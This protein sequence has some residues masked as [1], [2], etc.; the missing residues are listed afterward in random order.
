MTILRRQK[1]I[2]KYEKNEERQRWQ[3]SVHFLPLAG[4]A[5][6]LVAS[7]LAENKEQKL[8]KLPLSFQFSIIHVP[9]LS[10]SRFLAASSLCFL[11][12]ANLAKSALASSVL[13]AACIF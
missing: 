11:M 8:Q 2:F 7:S 12:M 6:A 5:F 4:P 1:N 13:P 3:Y 10:S 9:F